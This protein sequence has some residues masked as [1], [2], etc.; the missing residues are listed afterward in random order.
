M[1]KANFGHLSL[2]GTIAFMATAHLLFKQAGLHAA[3]YTDWYRALALNSWLWAGLLISASGMVCWLSTLRFRSLA[4]AY[5]WTSLIY[6]LT[7]LSSALLFGDELS[8]RYLTGMIFIVGGV[9][10]TA[11]ATR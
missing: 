11:G 3:Q 9:F 5:P 7:P 1:S 4:S 6:V 2:A 8:A 10:V